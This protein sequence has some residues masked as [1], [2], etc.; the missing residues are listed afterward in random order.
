MHANLPWQILDSH[1]STGHSFIPTKALTEEMYP[2]VSQIPNVDQTIEQTLSKYKEECK[3]I[4]DQFF[5]C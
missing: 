3:T 1:D 5:S 4:K 2:A